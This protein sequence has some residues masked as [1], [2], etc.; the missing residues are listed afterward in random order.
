MFQGMTKN[1]LALGAGILLMLLGLGLAG[2]FS[3][4][5]FF[6]EQ[7]YRSEAASAQG[8]VVRKEKAE[9]FAEPFGTDSTAGT[10]TTTPAATATA[11]TSSAAA[12]TATTHGPLIDVKYNLHY[13]FTPAGATAPVTGVYE[14]PKKLFERINE[15]DEVEVLYKA[16]RPKDDNRPLFPVEFGSS[17]YAGV[18]VL[19]GGCLFIAYLGWCFIFPEDE[20]VEASA[21]ENKKEKRKKK[22]GK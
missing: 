17:F 18:S 16:D 13:A 4:Q 10:K 21:A 2:F 7:V 20:V 8:V 6:E 3:Y 5:F 9:T 11:S 19:L 22:A 15:R 12:T 1:P 14:A